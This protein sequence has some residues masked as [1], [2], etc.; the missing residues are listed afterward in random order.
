MGTDDRRSL[1]SNV[2]LTAIIEGK[3]FR[4]PVRVGNVS[5]HGALLIGDR[6]PPGETEV[7]LHCN[8]IAVR[9][10]VA[11][12]DGG[13]AGIHFEERLPPEL[14]TQRQPRPPPVIT[15]DSRIADFRRPGFRGNQLTDEERKILE[16]W[17][18]HG[19]PPKHD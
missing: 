6:L 15:R 3:D 7:T 18:R 17:N 10:W 14:L 13:R 8:G 19:K 4:A 5:E 2:I 1:R 11:W 16:E 12:S 9:C